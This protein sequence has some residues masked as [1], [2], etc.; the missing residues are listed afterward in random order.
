FIGVGSDRA[1]GKFDNIS[2]KVLPPAITLDVTEEFD[3]GAGL[4][5]DV[6]DGE[7]TAEGG[8]L[9]GTS[10]AEGPPAIALATVER[11]DANAYLEIT[12]DISL[13]AG[14]SAGVVYDVYS[15]GTYKFILLDQ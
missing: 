15:D 1:R 2:A 4:V 14:T 3:G 12:A 10:G 11:L 9:T 5:S 13:V 6:V 8:T 7:W